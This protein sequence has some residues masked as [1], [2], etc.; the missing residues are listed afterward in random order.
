[1]IFLLFF[2]SLVALRIGE[3][4]LSNNNEK[5][6][7]ANGAV[8]YGKQHYPWMI[9]LHISFFISLLVEYYFQTAHSCNYYLL[10]SFCVLIAL[11]VWVITSL[12][13][14]WNTK[15]YHIPNAGL[16]KKGAY[17]YFKHP[18][19]AIVIVEIAI[20]PLMF[21]LYFTA[22]VFS[23]LNAAMLYVRISE[24]NKILQQR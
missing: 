13:K 16:I 19:Y 8:E 1:M 22:I 24:E 17:K 2:L 11:K 12:G 7:L 6:L 18:N 23:I 10:F 14:Y 3:L 5:W 9:A 20:I 4:I 21:H 15:I